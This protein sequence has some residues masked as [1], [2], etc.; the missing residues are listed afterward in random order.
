MK[1]DIRIGGNR[2]QITRTS[3]HGN[4]LV[5]YLRIALA[6][7]GGFA[8]HVILGGLMAAVPACTGPWKQ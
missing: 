2:L 8:A 1:S 7:F 6:A 3:P 5:N 4:F